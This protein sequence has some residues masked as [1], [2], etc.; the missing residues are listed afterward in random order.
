MASGGP[1]VSAQLFPSRYPVRTCWPVTR[2]HPRRASLPSRFVMMTG[3]SYA[4]SPCHAEHWP[5]GVPIAAAQSHLLSWLA[6]PPPPSTPVLI[7]RSRASWLT[8]LK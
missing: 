7:T 5:R 8:S 1:S 2:L 3:G 4:V 6:V